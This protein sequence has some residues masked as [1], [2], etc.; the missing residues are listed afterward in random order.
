MR[1]IQV[2]ISESDLR[3]LSAF[4]Q[5]LLSGQLYVGRDQVHSRLFSML[6][7]KESLP[8]PLEGQALYYMG[9]S[10]APEGFPLGS[11]GPT[12]SARMDPFSP[13][14][15]DEGLKIM[16][17]KGPR[18][19]QVVDAII[20]NNALYL[21]AFGGCGALY[22]STIKQ[23]QTVAFAELGAEA[24]L[25]LEVEDFPAIVAIDSTGKSVFTR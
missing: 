10:P 25:M 14:L 7:K 8:I 21:Q 20:R 11:C 15:L 3:S 4:D 5:V 6:E 18:S 1:K 12:T 9:P 19:S 2:P 13:R 16:I 24:L 23:V 17:G 22:A